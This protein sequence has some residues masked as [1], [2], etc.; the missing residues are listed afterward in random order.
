M[1][2][3]AAALLLEAAGF[4]GAS[5]PEAVGLAFAA[6]AILFVLGWAVGPAVYGPL[7]L[8]VPLR[9]MVEA[10]RDM[11]PAA[12]VMVALGA[13]TVVAYD[14]Q[15]V[16]ALA[17]FALVAVLPQSAL[18]YAART[19]PVAALDPLTAARRYARAMAVHLGLDRPARREL[20]AVIRLAH[21]ATS[22]ATPASTSATPSWTGA[23]S[24]A[25]PA[26]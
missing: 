10:L 9:G 5:V 23:R 1:A 26:T 6:G 15:G 14:G 4:A 19:R 2:G 25:P 24:P 13:V 21:A 11:A 3:V 17:L 7:W 12:A 22:T 8:G 18:T 16:L 20:D